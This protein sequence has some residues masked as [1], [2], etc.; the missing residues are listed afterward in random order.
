LGSAA[1]GFLIG[2]GVGLVVAHIVNETQ[3]TGEG[4][5]ENYIGLPLVLGSFTYFTIFVA[6]G[7]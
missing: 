6:M 2:A 1:V 7:D 4:K 3:R 5:L